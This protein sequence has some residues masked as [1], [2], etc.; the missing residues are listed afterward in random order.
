MAKTTVVIPI[1]NS[2]KQYPK[3]SYVTFDNQVFMSIRPANTNQSP[4]THN[5]KWILVIPDNTYP[6]W[7]SQWNGIDGYEPGGTV[8]YFGYLFTRDSSNSWHYVP[9][10]TPTP[11]TNISYSPGERVTYNGD[12]FVNIRGSSANRNPYQQK[13]RWRIIKPDDNPFAYNSNV[14]YYPR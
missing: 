1:Y 13:G 5:N 7:N 12:T 14:N 3:G 4:Y 10:T 11:W 9:S 6:T 2:S 8:S